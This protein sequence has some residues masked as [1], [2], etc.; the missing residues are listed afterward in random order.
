MF[1]NLPETILDE[2]ALQYELTD[3]EKDLVGDFCKLPKEQRNIV[4]TF[5]RGKK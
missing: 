2:L 4:I 3:L 5:L 1:T